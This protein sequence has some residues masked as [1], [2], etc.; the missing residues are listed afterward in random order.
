MCRLI[1]P[2]KRKLRLYSVMRGKLGRNDPCWCGS[3]QKYKKCHL[4]RESAKPV[5]FE[6]MADAMRAAS[7][8]RGCLHPLASPK[9]CDRIV[10]AHTIQRSRVLHEISDAANHVRTFFPPTPNPSTGRL[11]V[12]RVGWRKASTFTGFCAK[13]DNLT[14]RPLETATFDGS[15]E[16]CFL[17]GYRAVCHEIH[18]KSGLLKSLPAVKSLVDRGASVEAQRGIQ[19]MW[20]NWEAGTRKGLADFKELKAVMDEGLV[21]RDYSG[22][23]RAVVGFRGDLCVASTGAVSPNRDFDG[24]ELQVLHDPKAKIGALSFGIVASSEGGAAIFVWRRGE[25]APQGFIESLL[26]R[27]R[28]ILPSL[29]VQFMF[30]YIENTYFSD[31]WWWS[32]S[33]VNRDQLECLA[34]IGNAYYTDFSY[35][36]SKFVPWELTTVVVADS[37]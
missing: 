14:F 17:V 21:K 34:G 27:D 26:R 23:T 31:K 12:H 29:I 2:N 33:Q 24:S 16:Q 5:P 10:S 4:H 15:A 13:H 3:G 37:A 11:R 8:Q 6:A 7:S 25:T 35:S 36:S 28:R 19:E 32:L 22:W 18:Q 1:S 20:I 9:I 30:A